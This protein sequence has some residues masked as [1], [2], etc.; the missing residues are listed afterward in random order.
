[1]KKDQYP[2]DWSAPN[3]GKCEVCGYPTMAH[4]PRWTVRCPEHWQELANR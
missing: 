2:K 3:K 4:D 1:M